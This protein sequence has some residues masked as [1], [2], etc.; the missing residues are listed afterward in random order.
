MVK[1]IRQ[2][3]N[4]LF[5]FTLANRFLFGPQGR[6]RHDADTSTRLIPVDGMPRTSEP[7]RTIIRWSSSGRYSRFDTSLP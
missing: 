5:V 4:C 3:V 7:C 1:A 2:R 6:S